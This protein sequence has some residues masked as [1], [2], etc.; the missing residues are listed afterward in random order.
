MSMADIE[1]VFDE[2]GLEGKSGSSPY[3]F[4]TN[5]FMHTDTVIEKTLDS[6]QKVKE[7]FLDIDA[8]TELN[9]PISF[10]SAQTY[11]IY[12]ARRFNKSVPRWLEETK[13]GRER[14]L[15]DIFFDTTRVA[16]INKDRGGRKEA[17]EILSAYFGGERFR[18]PEDVAAN[19]LKK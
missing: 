19:L 8:R 12:L 13:N 11:Q 14:D 9:S 15:F 17:K 6:G 7:R 4:V 16:M 3:E 2:H 10:A 1:R 5:K 18:Q